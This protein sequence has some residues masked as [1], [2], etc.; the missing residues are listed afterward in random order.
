[1]ILPAKRM[2][3]VV[4]AAVLSL[5]APMAAGQ[6]PAEKFATEWGITSGGAADLPGGA[7]E[8]VPAMVLRQAGHPV[9]IGGIAGGNFP[10]SNS[11][12]ILI[13]VDMR[14][15]YGG[16]F[17]PLVLQW[18]FTARERLVPFIQM[19]GG[20]LWT[21]RDFPAGTSAFNFTPQGGFGAYWFTRPQQAFSFGVRYH[22]ISNGGR[23]KPNPGHNA[24]YF[25]GGLSW[26]K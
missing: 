18:N 11:I 19:G 3:A 16:G 25:Y 10:S 24:L 1:M 2:G 8:I 20:T 4:L 23:S 14:W 7:F 12:C 17:N 26:W 15:L 13:P 6:V 21:T 9:C 5:G 22:H